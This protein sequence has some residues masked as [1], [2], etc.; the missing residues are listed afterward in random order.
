MIPAHAAATLQF[1]S[2][3]FNFTRE[4]RP[5][6]EFSTS[7]L[8]HNHSLQYGSRTPEFPSIFSLGSWNNKDLFEPWIL[9]AARTVY[10]I[11]ETL[12]FLFVFVCIMYQQIHNL[13]TIYYTA[14][15]YTTP[16]CFDATARHLQG[17]RSQYLLSY[18]SM[19]KQ[20]WWYILKLYICYV[21]SI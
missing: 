3:H 8:H 11:T 2:L 10:N 9:S 15:C 7:I 12:F 4:M 6:K 19:W 17:A 5:K 13:S 14:L 1:I 16:T 20:Y 21:V 18:I